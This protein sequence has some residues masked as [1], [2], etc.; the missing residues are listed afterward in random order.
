LDFF[1]G[2]YWYQSWYLTENAWLNPYIE[3]FLDNSGQ[4]TCTLMEQCSNNDACVYTWTSFYLR[5]SIPRQ[6][7][8]LTWEKIVAIKCKLE[9]AHW[10]IVEQV[11]EEDT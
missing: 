11:Y 6:I 2:Q 3:N 9:N 5:R 4:K 8:E 10:V 1:N 7:D